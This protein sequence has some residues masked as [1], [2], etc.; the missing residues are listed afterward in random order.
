MKAAS[1]GAAG[2]EAL[3]ASAQAHA[4]R[5][6]FPQAI[7]ACEAALKLRPNDADSLV[8]LS[9]LHSLSGHYRL[10]RDCALQASRSGTTSPKVLAELVQRLR[11]F[12]ALPE[13]QECIARLRPL[14][15]IPIP[16]LIAIAAQLSYVNMSG[17]AIEY[18][19]EARRGDPDY[20]A[21]LLAR[22]QVLIYLGRFDEA[23]RDIDR[24]LRRA[25]QIAHGY[26]LRS[27]LGAGF[28]RPGDAAAI[29]SQLARPDRTPADV[30]LLGF[31]LHRTLDERGEHA[32][33]WQA[34]SLACRAKRS[35]M[36]YGIAETIALAD[37]LVSLPTHP[38][39]ACAVPDGTAT[40]IFIVGMHRSGTTLLEQLL[41]GSPQVRG[42]GELYDF[43]SA[44]REATDHHCRG[45]IDA[46]IVERAAGA[47]LADAGR[48][49]LQGIAWR[50]EGEPFFTDKLPSN[51]L[52][53]DFIC[54]AL[55]Q[56]RILHMV[57]DPVETCFSNLRELFSDANPW[58][59]D[60]LELAAYYRQYRRLMAHWH[61]V[62]PG[63]ILDVDYARLTRE[64]EAV[65][66]EVA[67]FCGIAF[68]PAMLEHRSR[69]RGVATASAVQV[70]D[71]VTVRGQ[72]KW[73]PYREYLQPLIGALAD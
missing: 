71:R 8:Q 68:D 32:E 42:I 51:F 2:F 11:T 39:T 22:A 14:S 47:D 43:T 16:L 35:S 67:A 38:G 61:T 36:Q 5:R 49:Y 19:D 52:N 73:A 56:A 44:M 63:R 17:Q 12:N 26:W 28:A 34:L 21:T 33:A 45:V 25:P 27:M 13:L 24:A 3:L 60:Q 55:P 30:A 62:W 18:L 37:A 6:E 69:S 10:G 65:M 70:R 58:S 48:R 29:R 7:A 31:A 54:R 59:Y 46:T 53:L 9:Y 40:P 66:R 15:N 1:P 4:S 72:P 64:P 50:L 23:A 57:R 41:D 20:P